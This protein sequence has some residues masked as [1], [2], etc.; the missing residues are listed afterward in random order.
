[1]K[2]DPIISSSLN[3][4]EAIGEAI[5]AYSRVEGTLATL[6]GSL[7]KISN[8]QSY[9]ILFAVQNVRSRNEVFQR[10]LGIIFDNQI[11]K[12]WQSCAAYLEA[13][14]KFRNAIAHWHP[15]IQIRL[16]KDRQAVDVAN[17]IRH[18]V[19][20]SRHKTLTLRDF[21]P[22]LVDCMYIQEELSALN[23]IV[24]AAPNTLPERFQRP[25]AR[26]NRALLRQSLTA[27]AQQPQR[28]PS[29]PKLSRAQKRAKALKEARKS[30]Q[31]D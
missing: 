30:A 5:E 27:K 28:P 16:N 14:Q 6:L 9:I 1:M 13:L 12:Y 25:I 22:F 21:N 26:R 11:K 15:I 7:L 19:P 17:G 24:Q 29:V 18:P 23:E 2:D 3:I 8:N 4:H 10:L 20:G 31:R